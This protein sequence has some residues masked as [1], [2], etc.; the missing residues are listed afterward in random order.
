MKKKNDIGCLNL[1]LRQLSSRPSKMN[2]NLICVILLSSLDPRWSASNCVRLVCCHSNWKSES[3]KSETLYL[4]PAAACWLPP[5]NRAESVAAFLGWVGAS[6][7]RPAMLQWPELKEAGVKLSKLNML[8]IICL[9]V[10]F[11]LYPL[12]VS[13]HFKITSPNFSFVLVYMFILMTKI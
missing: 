11:Y 13:L 3:W 4:Q 8:D 6:R 5:D 12:F 7:P 10:A 9:N 1:P 2:D